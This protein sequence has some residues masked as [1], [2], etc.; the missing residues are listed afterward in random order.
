M[1]SS[2]STTQCK[3][4]VVTGSSSGIGRATALELA[5]QGFAVVLHARRN[6]AGLQRT[7][8]EIFKARLDC[9]QQVLGITSDL[10]CPSACRDFVSAAFAWR[11]KV[12]CWVNNAGADVLT[13]EARAQSFESRLELLLR[14]DVQGTIRLSRLVA[15]RMKRQA[16]V[17]NAKPTI[18][19]TSWDQA[20]L[21]MEGEPGQLFCTTKAAVGA[22]STALALSYP[23]IRVNCFAPGWIQTDW[24]HTTANESWRRRAENESLAQRWG[25]A[26]DIARAISWLASD[27]SEF[28]NG[29]ILSI[30][31][32]RRFH[33][34]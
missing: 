21:G 32:G 22:F 2:T 28:I 7:A 1:N 12:D 15:T 4:A 25:T 31:G 3:V 34:D 19:N 16:L 18:I 17:S 20:N 27:A 24:G 8:L 11:G 9:G 26:E 29:Q 6:L 33:T 13:G 23:T 10:G 14:V 5:S 30:N